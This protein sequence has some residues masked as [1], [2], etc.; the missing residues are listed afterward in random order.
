M[1]FYCTN[2]WAEVA[3]SAV[4]CP[5]CGDDIVARQARSDYVA[6]L[7]AAL[8]H[9]EPTTPVRAAWI[10]GERR[11]RAAVEPLCRVIRESPDQF[12]LERAVEALGKIGDPRAAAALDAATRHPSLRVRERAQRALEAVFSAERRGRSTA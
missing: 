12:L 1:T 5:R 2:C 11:E 4:V 6:K 3:E 10:L 7:I 9:P 8:R